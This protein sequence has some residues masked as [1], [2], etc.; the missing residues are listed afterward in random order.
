MNIQIFGQNEL[1]NHI[2]KRLNSNLAKFNKTIYKA[3][4]E[5]MKKELYSNTITELEE[6]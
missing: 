6:I 4:I 5:A 1:L 2:D 3:R